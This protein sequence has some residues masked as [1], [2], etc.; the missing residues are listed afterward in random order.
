MNFFRPSKKQSTCDENSQKRIE[1]LF[2]AI[3]AIAM[4]MIA[5]G[6]K[7]PE[8]NTSDI[9]ALYALFGEITVYFISFIVLS[10]IWSVHTLIYSSHSSLG[11]PLEM[12][13]NIILMFFITLFPILTQL[14]AA[15]KNDLFLSLTY[16][17][18]YGLMEV[19][20]VSLLILANKK[21]IAQRSDLF[22]DITGIVELCRGKMDL[23]KYDYVL[24]KLRLTERYIDDPAT[25]SHLYQELTAT[26][27]EPV[28]LQI[29]QKDKNQKMQYGTIILFYLI[30]FTAVLLSVLA[31]MV[32]PP[33]LFLFYVNQLSTGGTD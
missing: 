14:I 23:Q 9:S 10:S 4:T 16:L 28:Q 18:C 11:T 25:F 6:I 3:I 12:I 20:V 19:L 22:R 2:D 30:S 8:Q 7:I 13:L 27:P 15:S 5:L 31:M 24:Q 29:R 21:S 26:L 17:G 1:T 32:N 33:P